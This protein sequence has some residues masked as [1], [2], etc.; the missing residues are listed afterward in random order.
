MR[1][2][3]DTVSALYS[4]LQSLG[5]YEQ[6]C[7]A[8]I[9]HVA[10]SKVDSDTKRKW[11]EHI[12]YVSLP[13]WVDCCAMLDKRCQQIN[14]NLKGGSGPGA[15]QS[16]HQRTYNNNAKI[17]HAM[18]TKRSSQRDMLCAFCSK[19]GHNISTCQGFVVLPVPQRSQQVKKLNLCLNCL[20]KGH[21]YSQCP[22]K[23]SCRFCKKSHHSLLHDNTETISLP[24]TPPDNSC[25]TNESAS[26]HTTSVEALEP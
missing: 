1:H 20:A 5:S 13:K 2:I 14:A 12:D 23:Y 6:I 8:F 22:S 18:L 16:S 25:T 24:S 15:A 26:V 19:S 11:D 9:I 7:D 3:V 21:G 4:S 17:N 10:L